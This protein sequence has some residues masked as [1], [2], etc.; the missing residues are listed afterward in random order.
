MGPGPGL[1]EVAAASLIA[2]AAGYLVVFAPAGLGAREVVYLSLLHGTAS[3]TTLAAGALLG[4]LALTGAEV[5]VNLVLGVLAN[6]EARRTPPPVPEDPVP[7][8]APL[9]PTP[10]ST[11]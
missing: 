6:R 10:T 11:P 7:E 3:S 5:V 4:R 1:L 9:S 8:R 2:W